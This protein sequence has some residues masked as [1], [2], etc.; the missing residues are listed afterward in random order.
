MSN[1]IVPSIELVFK[2]LLT[3]LEKKLEQVDLALYEKLSEDEDKHENM[4]QY[5]QNSLV[6]LKSFH[7]KVGSLAKDQLKGQMQQQL[8]F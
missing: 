1:Q 6:W 5:Y 8:E 3:Q 2:K 4:V 7:N